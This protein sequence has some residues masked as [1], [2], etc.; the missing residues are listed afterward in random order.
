MKRDRDEMRRQ[1][2]FDEARK[3]SLV[4]RRQLSTAEHSDTAHSTHDWCRWRARGRFVSVL[5][6]SNRITLWIASL[7]ADGDVQNSTTLT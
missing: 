7:T 5:E 4:F 3:A 6:V 1:H 2:L